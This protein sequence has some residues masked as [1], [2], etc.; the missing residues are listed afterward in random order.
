MSLS[1][2]NVPNT[3]RTPGVV[4]EVDASRALQGLAQNPHKA[5]IIGQMIDT[6]SAAYETLY[7]ITSEILADSYFETGSILSR[8]CRKFKEVNP[9]TELFAIA[10]N[11]GDGVKASA[12]IFFSILMSVALE[13]ISTTDETLY[14]M[15]NGTQIQQTLTNTWSVGEVNSAL[16]SAINAISAL[17]VIANTTATSALTLIAKNSGTFG[18]YINIRFNY[19]TGQ[20]M[21][22]CFNVSGASAVLL[23]MVGGAADPDIDA[24]WAVIENEQFQYI[25]HNYIDTTNLTALETELAKRFK[26]LE[27]KAG[28]GFGAVRAVLAS[29]TAIGNSRN[30]AHNCIIAADDA[31][32][33][34]EEWAAVL[35]GV[36]ASNLN[37]DPA[38]PLH[39]LQLTGLLAPPTANRFTRTERETLLYDGI[40]TWITDS[41][42][43]VL[44]ERCITT[45][46]KNALGTPDPTYLDVQTL[47]TLEEI[48]YQYKVRMQNRFIIPR[49]KL[50][51]NT[52]PVQPGTYVATPKTIK[53][54]II[55]LFALLRDR[56]LI[57]NLDDFITNLRVERNTTD[58]NRVDVLL[59]PDLINQ[60]RMLASL[61][62]FIL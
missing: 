53:S 17:P 6:G 55:S 38:R 42:A 32:N 8:M 52:F 30:N 47:A 15:I 60:F 61:M 50:A 18:N 25:I 36:A 21:P 12:A 39:F 41:S 7:A 44:I 56:G 1:F 10:L 37:N 23:S 22:T 2:N 5:L 14:L 40:V 3:T 24:A 20:S 29:A 27:D 9:N 11:S 34:P 13:V 57:E 49:F 46:Q 33:A 19:H 45:Y 62:Q 48:K 51:D 43:N 58:K 31:P 59:P 28:Q 54:E 26:P 16:A 4:T 35:G